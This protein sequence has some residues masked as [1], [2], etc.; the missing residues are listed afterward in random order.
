LSKKNKLL[1]FFSEDERSIYR[2]FA[3]SI[4]EMIS[5]IE[6]KSTY[7]NTD[8]ILQKLEDV[9]RKNML[10]EE[11]KN[12][13]AIIGVFLNGTYYYKQNTTMDIRVLKNFINL[14][15]SCSTEKTKIIMM[16]IQNRFDGIKRYTE[17]DIP[18]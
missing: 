15:K 5:K 1:D 16:N 8:R 11:I 10:E 7:T 14:L 9:Y 18:F 17:D 2:Y 12:T 13:R 4:T 6:E 3:D